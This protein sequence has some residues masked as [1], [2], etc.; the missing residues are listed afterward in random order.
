MATGFPILFGGPKKPWTPAEIPT[1]LWLDAN[2][3]ST[4][5]LNGS[6]V[7]AWADKSGNGRNVTQGT[8]ANQ[9]TYVTSGISGKPSLEW[10][11][12][13]NS[14]HLVWSGTAFTANKIF[15]VADYDGSDPFNNYRGV[16]AYFPV[17][18][19]GRVWL[20]S[21][22]GLIWYNNNTKFLNGSTT[23]SAVALP[24]ISSPFFGYNGTDPET[25][26]TGMYVGSDSSPT[27][28]GWLGKIAEVIA[29]NAP[30]TDSIEKL[31]GY[32][33]WKWA[34]ESLLPSGHP[35]KNSPP[36]V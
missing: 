28:R 25:L 11:T 3:A 19:P 14:K 15:I 36:T 29:V 21:N 23:V 8:A 35:Y 34:L 24:T 20:T 12:A 17:T 7:S 32:L 13:S 4:I 6:T 33:A 5:T 16:F 22:T 2:D 10:G 27:N 1:A 31:E 18:N 30:N 9:P 26:R